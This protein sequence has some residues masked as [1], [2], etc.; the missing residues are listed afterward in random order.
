MS[1][2]EKII[3]YDKELF[4]YLNSLGTEPW[5]NF[6]ITLTNQFSW[7][8]LFALL[9]FLVFRSYGWKKGLILMVLAALLITFSDQFVNFIKDSFGRLRPNNDSSI[10]ELIRILK[11]PSSFSFVSGH[12]TTSF[13]VSTF[14]IATLKNH[15]KSPFFLLIWPIL[16][17][18]SRIYI[19]V[20]FPMDIFVGMLLGILIGYIFYRISLILL[21]KIP[22]KQ[23]TV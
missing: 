11:R 12:S 17:A 23:K 18:Y 4:I 5:D 20:H 16:F 19:G 10:N 15:Y 8:P 22:E 3:N 21:N 7:I 1:F 2:L 14:I 9:L 6:W 13:A